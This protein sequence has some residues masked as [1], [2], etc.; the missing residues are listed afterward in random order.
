MVQYVTTT[1]LL[2]TVL[3][4]AVRSFV[5]AAQVNVTVDDSQTSSGASLIQYTPSTLWNDGTNCS[6]CTAHPDASRAMDGTWHD[7]THAEGAGDDGLSFATLTFTGMFYRLW[8]TLQTSQDLTMLGTAIYVYGILAHTSTSPDGNSDMLFSMDG[9]NVGSFAL[10][11][12]NQT[13]YD[14][15]VLLYAN[16][17]IPSG[18]HTFVLQNGRVGGAKSLVLLDYIVYT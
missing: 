17:S 16:R 4:L 2:S 6:G 13:T 9:Q 5:S 18:S 10:S 3:S 15:N 8:I 1:T 11:P 12:T 14:Y 7:S